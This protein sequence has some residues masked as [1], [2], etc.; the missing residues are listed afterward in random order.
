M[1]LWSPVLM[2][3]MLFV[4]FLWVNGVIEA[5]YEWFFA[6]GQKADSKIYQNDFYSGPRARS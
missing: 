4:M 3:V 6:L 5:H 1:S 2:A